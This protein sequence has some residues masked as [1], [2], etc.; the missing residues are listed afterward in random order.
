MGFWLTHY[1]TLPQYY[2]GPVSDYVR[3]PR[4][5]GRRPDPE[6]NKKEIFE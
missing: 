5:F 2:L 3:H 4:F 1:S 6:F